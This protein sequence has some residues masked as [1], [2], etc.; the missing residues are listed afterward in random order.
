M[1]NQAKSKFFL[2]AHSSQGY[3]FRSENLCDI[4]SG[5]TRIGIVAPL[6]VG[7]SEIISEVTRATDEVEEIYSP[8]MPSTPQAIVLHEEK[9]AIMSCDNIHKFSTQYPCICDRIYSVYDCID[10]NTLLSFREDII[11]QLDLCDKLN[12][13]LRNYL[14]AMGSLSW[15]MKEIIAPHILQNKIDRYAERFVCDILPKARREQPKEQIRLLS[16]LSSGDNKFMEETVSALCTNIYCIYDESGFVSAN[17]LSKIRKIALEN[18]HN[19]TTCYAPLH[20]YSQIEHIIFPE[21]DVA[22]CTVKNRD[23]SSLTPYRNVNIE[24]FLDT[25]E[26]KKHRQNRKFLQKVSEELQREV[27][28]LVNEMCMRQDKVREYY[29]LVLD[30]GDLISK[31]VLFIK[32]N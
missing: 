24:R 4:T 3:V 11:H 32:Q 14:Y 8:L 12:R 16:S 1:E 9:I 22:I 18:K 10:N 21:I 7:M 17:I 29:K 2:G 6:G 19:V 5:Y 26:L 20:P 13:H 23:D 27:A 31:I 28:V 30:K 25:S 15:Q